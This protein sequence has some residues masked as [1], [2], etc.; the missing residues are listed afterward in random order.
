MFRNTLLR[1]KRTS[2]NVACVA[3]DCKTIYD[4]LLAVIILMGVSPDYQT[5]V[6]TI[7]ASTKTLSSLHVISKLQNAERRRNVRN[8]ES[9]ALIAAAAKQH[10][11]CYYC[12][13]PRNKC[14]RKN[15]YHLH[16]ELKKLNDKNAKTI[17]AYSASASSQ[18]RDGVGSWLLDS[19]CNRQFVTIGLKWRN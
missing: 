9:A 4:N 13:T 11:F 19:G 5:V 8:K 14:Y 3:S 1:F 10:N 12:N 16:P 7:D 18:A 6:D 17:S 2:N 15:C